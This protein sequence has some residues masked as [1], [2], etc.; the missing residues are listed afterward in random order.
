VAYDEDLAG[1]V[2]E[3]I[4]AEPGVTEKRMFGGLAFL[5]A[6]NM[7]VSVSGQGGLLLRCDP[8]DTE[9]LAG[10]PHAARFQMRGR[11]LHG[12]LRVDVEGVRTK[13]QLERWVDRGVSY[14]RSLPP[15]G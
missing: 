8:A 9:A 15:K 10:K 11:E 13:R 6:G 7:S 12:W 2:R 5:I 3:L 14:A 4:A 1:R